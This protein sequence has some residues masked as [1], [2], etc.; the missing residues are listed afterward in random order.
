MNRCVNRFAIFVFAGLALLNAGCAA[1]ARTVAY[2]D[3][4][5][6]VAFYE[7]PPL[8]MVEPGIYVVQGSAY[9]VYYVNG[10]YW[11]Y[12]DGGWYRS[13]RWNDS[14]VRVGG[15][16]IPGVIV[17]RDHHHYVRYYGHPHAHVWREPPPP[18]RWVHGRGPAR[19]QRVDRYQRPAQPRIDR[20][21]RPAQP[22]V[23]HGPAPGSSR[24]ERPAP[25]PRRIEHPAPAPRRIESQPRPSQPSVEPSRAAP[26][27]ADKRRKPRD[28]QPRV[29]RKD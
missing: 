29:K 1:E 7:P 10:A 27:K 6:A 25:A 2:V 13:R 12:Y 11:S 23:E 28:A 17:Y 15:D 20:S 9:P 8:I 3:E 5:Y 16:V 26:P 19:P 18:R 14:W 21:P 22:R 24:I 4:P